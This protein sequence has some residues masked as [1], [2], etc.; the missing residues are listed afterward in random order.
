MS[1][2]VAA[3]RASRGA[4]RVQSS[5]QFIA[6]NVDDSADTTS[7]GVTMDVQRLDASQ[8]LFGTIT[9]LAPARISYQ[10][11][12]MRSVSVSGGTVG[13]TFT[14]KDTVNSSFPGG[15]TTT[16]NSGSG[17]DTVNVQRTTGA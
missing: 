14:V 2:R 13:N 5:A 16:L 1:D 17:I 7:R 8:V 9:N 3:C 11:N 10:A 6:L 4:L 15:V 12:A